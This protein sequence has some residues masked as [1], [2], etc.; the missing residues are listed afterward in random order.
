M[1]IGVLSEH[2]Q[3]NTILDLFLLEE[4]K[5]VLCFTP[6]FPEKQAH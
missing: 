3:R 5:P 6:K 1:V 4:I 2:E